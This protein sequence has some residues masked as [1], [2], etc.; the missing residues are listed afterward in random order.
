[1]ES[2]RTATGSRGLRLRALANW[3]NLSTPLGLAVAKAGRARLRRGPDRM[4]L[5]EGYRPGFPRAGA[6]T[7]GSVLMVPG[8]KLDA[9]V[10]EHPQIFEH[11]LA[12][13]RQWALALGLPFLPLYLAA[14]AWSR[15]RTG[16][17][18]EAN[19]F[20]VRAGLAKGGYPDTVNRP[21]SRP[22]ISGR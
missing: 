10:Q 22:R 7:I 2:P 11:E 12:H 6:F 18:H 3:L 4:W 16:N 17:F 21:R 1:M 5:A 13:A 9:L 14:T 15:L 19:I 8:G 20:E